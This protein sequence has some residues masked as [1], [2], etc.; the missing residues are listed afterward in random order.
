[1]K[2]KITLANEAYALEMQH[3]N[4]IG[5][6]GGQNTNTPLFV[7][8]VKTLKHHAL[9]WAV[10]KCKYGDGLTNR[11]QPWFKLT[12]DGYVF[13][14]TLKNG[15]NDGQMTL[16]VPSAEWSTGGLIIEQEGISLIPTWRD[17]Q[18]IWKAGFEVDDK[19]VEY[20][21]GETALIAAMRCFVALHL[22][23]SF[24][25]PSVLLKK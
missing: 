18:R 22:D 20:F 24:V 14:H 17:G 25:I 11:G 9:D 6:P 4:E 16:F 15:W 7:S 12:A 1:M 21:E 19:E 23:E 3:G 10:A 5:H 8:Q 13:H 2:D